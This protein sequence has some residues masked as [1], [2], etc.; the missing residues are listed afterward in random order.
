MDVQCS[1][2]SSEV[3]LTIYCLC[4]PFLICM[5]LKKK[6]EEKRREFHRQSPW[7]QVVYNCWV[8]VDGPHVL[9]HI[10]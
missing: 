2:R 8:G 4:I 5:I 10:L 6:K 3:F 7:Y 1:V 9:Q